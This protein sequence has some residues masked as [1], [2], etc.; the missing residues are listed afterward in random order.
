MI[1]E[2]VVRGSILPTPAISP[3]YNPI[4][5][6]ASTVLPPTHGSPCYMGKCAQIFHGD[7]FLCNMQIMVQ[8][9]LLL[10][11]NSLRY[12]VLDICVYLYVWIC[13]DMYI[14]V[15]MDMYVWICVYIYMYVCGIYIYIYIYIYRHYHHHN[16]S[17]LY[18]YSLILPLLI[19]RNPGN[20]TLDRVLSHPQA[21]IAWWSHNRVLYVSERSEEHWLLKFFKSEGYFYCLY[22][23]NKIIVFKKGPK[24][25]WR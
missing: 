9:A 13:M 10:C 12:V 18:V 11:S 7:L 19:R 2:E 22:R 17:L 1:W 3:H 23:G 25:I 21:K 8:R 24:G 5:S 6:H 14:Y 20:A 4:H 16:V 15:C